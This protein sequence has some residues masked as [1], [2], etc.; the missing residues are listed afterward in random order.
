MINPFKQVIKIIIGITLVLAAGAGA[1]EKALNAKSIFHSK[2]I[3]QNQDAKNIELK[4]LAGTPL[5][6]AMVYTS[7]P[8]TCPL[9]M[10]DLKAIEKKLTTEQKAKI[11]FAVFAF[12]AKRDLPAKLLSFANKHQVDLKR[13]S[14]YHGSAASVRELAALLGIKFKELGDGDFE[15]SNLITILDAEGVVQ[16]QQI[17]LRQNPDATIKVLSRLIGI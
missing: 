12:D 17:G 8:A 6:L 5:V 14:F 2:T 9:I 1:N 16:H 7:C 15:H 4:D 3:W 13:W 10:N 11:R